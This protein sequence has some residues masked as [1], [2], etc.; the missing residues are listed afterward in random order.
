MSRKEARDR[1]KS[2]ALSGG[3]GP[4]G[5]YRPKGGSVGDDKVI[6]LT[7]SGPKDRRI[8]SSIK[9][10]VPLPCLTEMFPF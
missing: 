3:L 9:L 5:G 10:S 1:P 2:S 6:D 7:R 4:E 8:T